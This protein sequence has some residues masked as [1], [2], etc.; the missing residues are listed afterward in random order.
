[1]QVLFCAE[2]EIRTPT[3]V[4]RRYHLKV[5]RLP[6]SPPPLLGECKFNKTVQLNSIHAFNLPLFFKL[7]LFRLKQIAKSYSSNENITSKSPAKFPI[8]LYLHKFL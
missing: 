7:L 5:V 2:E 3:P 4:K 1:M 6:I 8:V